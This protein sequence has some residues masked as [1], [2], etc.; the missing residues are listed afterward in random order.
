MAV[1]QSDES[2]IQ[3]LI[4]KAPVAEAAA[5]AEGEEMLVVFHWIRALAYS[6]KSSRRLRRRPA[7]SKTK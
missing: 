4:S 7:R 1:A 6:G 2:E 5:A 3:I